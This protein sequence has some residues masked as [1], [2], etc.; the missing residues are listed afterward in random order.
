MAAAS[1]TAST[2]SPPDSS[3]VSEVPGEVGAAT[4]GEVGAVKVVGNAPVL[5]EEAEAA[6]TGDALKER[7]A[8]SKAKS[9]EEE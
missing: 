3:S 7:T 8:R 1:A 9:L 6:A 4:S 2:S 5:D